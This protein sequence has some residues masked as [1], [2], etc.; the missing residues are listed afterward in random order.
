MRDDKMLLWLQKVLFTAIS[1]VSSV[2]VP[3]S[4]SFRSAAIFET[5]LGQLFQSCKYSSY[6]FEW[7]NIKFSKAVGQAYN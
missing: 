1:R 2:K 4:K 5:P 3:W 6:L 7:G